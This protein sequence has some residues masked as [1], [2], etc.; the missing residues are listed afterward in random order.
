LADPW[1]ADF[2]GDGVG[3]GDELLR[4]TDPLS[5]ADVDANGL[6]DDWEQCYF[7][8]I[9]VDPRATAPGGGMTNLQ[10]FTLGSNPNH[11]PPPPTITAGTAIL[12]Q[13]ADTPL[14]PAADS[15]SLLQNGNFSSPSLGSDDWDTF[16]GITGWTAISGTL[17][18]LQQIEVNTTA[19]A[20]QYGELDAH[21]PTSDHR[22]D[23]DHGIQQT[24]NLPRGHYLLFFDYRGREHDV[25]AGSFTVKVKSAGSSSD[26]LLVTKN[27]ASTTTWKRA[28]VSFE[29]TGGNPN[30]TTLP[31]TL[32]FD[33]SDARDSYGA[34][35][36][37]ILLLPVGIMVDANLDGEMSF[38]VAATHDKDGTT[39]EKPYKFWINGDMDGNEQDFP[40]SPAD[41]ALN[42]LMNRRGLE[43]FARL[44]VSLKGLTE[45]VKTGGVQLQ[46]EWK[47]LDGSTTW[48][49]ADHPAIKLLRAVETDG[50]RKYVEEETV[51]DQQLG[52]PYCLA[53]GQA[54]RDAGTFTL[55]LS[56]ATLATL[57]EAT[58]NLYFLFE[59]ATAGKG[60][61]VLNL[62]KGGQKI[63]EYPPL[64]LDIR[65][66]KNMYERWSV[67]PMA[68]V[69]SSGA[70]PLGTAV[71]ST[72][73]LPAGQ[74][75]GFTYD[76]QSPEEKKCIV[77]AHGWNMT[78]ADKDMFAE[79]AYKRLWWQGYKGRFAAFQWPTTHSFDPTENW[80]QLISN[81]ESYDKGDFI[82][83]RSAPAL[84]SLLSQLNSQCSDQVYLM[85][86]S[87]GNVVSGEALR[88]LGRSGGHINTYVAC[89]AAVQSECYDPAMTTSFPINYSY[90]GGNFGPDT[91]DIFSSWL[92]P[93]SAG[94]GKKVNF[95]NLNDYALNVGVWEFDQI[96]KPDNTGI[97]TR[98]GWHFLFGSGNDQF[99]RYTPPA[100]T[101]TRLYLGGQADPKDQYE[102][103]SYSAEPLSR[104]LG[105]VSG[106]VAGFDTTRDMLGQN[107][108]K[109]D[110]HNNSFKDREWHS[111]QF[112][113]TN[114]VVQ[115]FWRKLLN[116]FGILSQ[117]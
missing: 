86:H 13:S 25:E 9:G 89:E 64:Y 11:P 17:I 88:L 39:A 68:N 61:L 34:Y 30:S 71:I 54:G 62:I 114:M 104:A 96:S 78:P 31:I 115:E 66:M 106:G 69:P 26:V 60:R 117:P 5:A 97:N 95:Y 18:E 20:G 27:S 108:W 116:D 16:S 44:W 113:F 103:M 40:P 102:I 90:L 37:N 23:S 100:L 79:T 111:G 93:N 94:V 2:D 74:S 15:Q 42:S 10:H 28:S 99:W 80:F 19:N 56:A 107:L 21:W 53:L 98:W 8:R 101:Y 51:A 55:P 22:G 43:D 84:A 12:E 81:R 112:Q 46:L 67:D 47:S 83:W 50:G 63:G 29:I 72:R 6:P 75:A 41:Y 14:Y 57:S 32:L 109:Y 76:A 82:A 58:P 110:P 52:L 73:A 87:M 70:D 4:G 65:D 85:G 1:T 59:G 105:R 77:F 35:I 33:S 36:D 24:V 49:T 3:N 48:P 92:A 7:H 45:M 91:P 38:T